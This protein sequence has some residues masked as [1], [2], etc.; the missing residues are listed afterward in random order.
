MFILQHY[1]ENAREFNKNKEYLSEKQ[2]F[3]Q[4]PTDIP[5]LLLFN[6]PGQGCPK[7]LANL[8][9]IGSN[10]ANSGVYF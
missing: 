2:L 10:K 8:G 7:R 3:N 9:I 5:V 4:F 6:C 1:S